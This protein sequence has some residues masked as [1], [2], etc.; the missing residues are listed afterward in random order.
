[1]IASFLL[2]GE[3]EY[4]ATMVRALK[5]VHRCP[6]IQM[7]DLK[8]PKVAGVDEVVR[9]PFKVPLMLYRF[10]HLAAYPHDDMLIVDTDV[11][12]KAPIDDVW[13]HRFD[14]AL[15][16][17]EPG[18]LYEGDGDDLS[19]A[20]PFNTGVMFSRSTE[21][22][23]DCYAWLAREDAAKQ[24]WYGDQLAVAQV[25]CRATYDVLGLPCSVFNWAP[26]S[27]NDGSTARFW[28]YKGAIRKKWIIPSAST[29]ASISVR[30]LPITPVANPS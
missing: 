3:Q 11:I 22:W 17:R 19:S 21:F 29:S 10:K 27:I 12:A 2:V 5:D 16:H 7:S 4:A 30:P 25:V 9:L 14:V 20:M 23:A 26:S 6:V 28:H 1:M 24:R 8:S 15:T 18:E 13:L